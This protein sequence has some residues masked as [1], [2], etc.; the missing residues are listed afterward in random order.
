MDQARRDCKLL[1]GG[2]SSQ[3]L[4]P[5]T[6]QK[7]VALT[8]TAKV[9]VVAHRRSFRPWLVTMTAETFFKIL[10]GDFAGKA[11]SGN[12]EILK[13]EGGNNNFTGANR[14]HREETAA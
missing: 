6:P 11:Q 8:P 4:P 10:R 9:P 7:H 14:D 1:G 13:F 12:A 5:T 3:F 2:V